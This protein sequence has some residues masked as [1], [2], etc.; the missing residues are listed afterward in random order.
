[1]AS[2]VTEVFYLTRDNSAELV[3]KSEGSITDLTNVTKIEIL[4]T[5]C[6]WSVNSEDTPD[7]FEIGTTDGR[8]VLKLGQQPINPGSYKCQVIVY[9]PT[10]IEGIVWGEV[11][12]I[13]RQSCPAI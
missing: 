8:L 6:T 3:L 4:E 13:F 7:A 1:M 9:D 11:K 10:N 5:G 12:L 2:T